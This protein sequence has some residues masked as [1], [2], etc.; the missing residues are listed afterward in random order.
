MAEAGAAQQGVV[1][2][3]QA[4]VAAPVD[5]QGGLRAG[6]LGSGQVGVDVGA[7]EGVD[8]LLGVADEHE[9]GAAAAEAEAEDVPLD[10]IGVLELVDQRH[11]VAALQP[12]PDPRAVHRV[13]EGGPQADE[14]IVVGQDAG[15]AFAPLHLLPHPQGQ[16]AVHPGRGGSG[17]KGGLDRGHRVVDGGVGHPQGVGPAEG[18]GPLSGVELPDVEVVDHLGQEVALVL[19]DDDLALDVA[20]EAEP[21]ED[22][23]AEPVGGGDGGGVVVGQSGGEAPAALVDLG[24]GAGGEEAE[25]VVVLRRGLAGRHPEE[26]LLRADQ[27]LPNPVAQL[28]GGH[29]GEGDDEQLVEGDAAGDVAGGEGGDGEGLARPGAGFEDGHSRGR[30]RPAHVEGD[31]GLL[32]AHRSRTSSAARRALQRR[33]A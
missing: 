26:A 17:G 24:R 15:Q 21:A 13:V 29:A 9:G 5:G 8:G 7:P 1:G 20:G 22:V 28:A 2:V 10:G 33:R 12:G 6:H 25:D 31:D 16:A 32:G 23:L 18:A 27:P 11:P 30:Q 19:Q 14:E 3:D 4:L